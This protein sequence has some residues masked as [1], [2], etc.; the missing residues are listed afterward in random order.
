MADEKHDGEM[1]TRE[2]DVYNGTTSDGRPVTIT[3]SAILQWVMGVA[4]T[5]I[6]VAVISLYSSVQG[7]RETQAVLIARQ[8]QTDQDRFRI[9]DWTRES[10]MLRQEIL[11]I[12]QGHVSQREFSDAIQDMRAQLS[13]IRRLLETRDDR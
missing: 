1:R 4:A 8:E 9:Q 12:S 11:S 13:E 3:V 10:A 6:T 5:L 7:L 2:R